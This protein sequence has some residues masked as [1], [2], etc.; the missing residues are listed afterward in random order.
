MDLTEPDASYNRT[1][2]ETADT[3]CMGGTISTSS[4]CGVR[5]GRIRTGPA[6][7]AHKAWLPALADAVLSAVQASAV[8][9]SIIRATLETRL[10]G[11]P[12]CLACS[13]TISSFGAMYTQ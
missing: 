2:K 11:K 13:R 4:H 9:G 1:I 10:T 12:P 5:D 6:P 7:A 3:M 8:V